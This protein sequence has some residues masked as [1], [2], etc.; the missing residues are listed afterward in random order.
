MRI[1]LTNDDGIDSPGIRALEKC[2][3]SSHELWI[4]APD[5]QRSGVSHSITVFDPIVSEKVAPQAY[6]CS[7]MP[8]DC[9][10]VALGELLESK[11]DLVL[12]GINMGA[13]LSMNI[14]FSGTAAA[15]HAAALMGI[16]GVALSID[17]FVEPA[18]F[19]SLTSFVYK[20]LDIFVE[21]W[22]P[23]CFFNINAPNGA[24]PITEYAI[25]HPAHIQFRSTF[26]GF[27]SP[28]GARYSFFQGH[29]DELEQE[30]PTD[31]E[32]LASG[33]IAVCLLQLYP[34][35]AQIGVGE[36]TPPY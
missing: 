2:L 5:R 32:T 22:K 14:V 20:N 8:A 29:M 17:T 10:F 26:A 4:V 6:R 24:E 23:G 15:A 3:G 1:L 25:C 7:G 18:Y 9:V 27:E 12:S 34:A 19:D 28:S 33:K 31:M 35:P 13:N 21:L 30:G 36:F 11:P 16:P